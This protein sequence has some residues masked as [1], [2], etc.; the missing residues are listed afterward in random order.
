MI[1]S[2]THTHYSKHA[3][4]SVDALAAAAYQ[5]GVTVLTITDHAPYPIDS[6]NRLLET[7]LHD[8]FDDIA[9]VK[10]QYV[11]KMTILA[12]LECDYTPGCT[13]YLQQLLAPW[14]LDFV[15]G[16]IHYVPKGEE[17]V[18]VWDLPRL[19][20]PAVLDVYFDTLRDMLTCGLFDAIAHVDTLLRGVPEDEFDARLAPLLPLF[21]KHGV[22]YELN[23]SGPRKSVY[24]P[25][26]NKESAP[27]APSYP[28]R[29]AV[30]TLLDAG[31]TMTIGSDA[32]DPI[33]AGAGIR[34]LL[35]ELHC[36]GLHEVV[37]YVKRQPV[38]V[39]VARLLE[40]VWF[41]HGA[42]T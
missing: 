6:N 18:K 1:D 33:D 37:Y 40:R 10:A 9:R 2:H 28:S 15:I 17:L 3:R 23:A 13:D 42:A 29:R 26:A 39:P 41:A 19:H 32:H 25:V 35:K 4:G 31:A 36:V 11:G 16:A 20:A 22:S 38:K 12:G 5:H 14:P 7:E 30:A 8:Y 21:A 24:C 34:P 27:G